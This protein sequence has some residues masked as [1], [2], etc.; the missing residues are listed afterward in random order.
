[1]WVIWPDLARL[2]GVLSIAIGE[3]GLFR[4]SDIISGKMTSWDVENCIE[5]QQVGLD[6]SLIEV[7]CVY[8][9][10]WSYRRKESS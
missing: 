3:F 10:Q 2:T 8:I 7:L 6:R 5:E 1:M 4:G 9:N